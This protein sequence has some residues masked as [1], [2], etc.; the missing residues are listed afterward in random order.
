MPW[1]S[2]KLMGGLP[3]IKPVSGGS[4][5]P[6][7]QPLLTP[8]R[9]QKI[10]ELFSLALGRE[11][12]QRAA[13][14]DEVCEGDEALRAE[15]ESLLASAESEQAATRQ[16]FKSVSTQPSSPA[17]GDAEDPMI[18]RR[19]GDYR[20][21]RRIGYGGMAAVYLASRADEQF[22]MHAAI[23]V[24]R[25]D[26]D[27]AELL[28]RFFNERQTLA[29]L[30]HP[31]I[32]KLLDGG[33]T[34]E[35]LPYLVMD[36]VEGVPIDEYCDAHGLSIQKRLQLFCTVCEAVTYAHQHHVIHRDLKPNNILVTADGTTKLLDFGIAKV[37][38]TSEASQVATRTANRHLTPAFAS[39][40]QVRGETVAATTDVYSLG[41]VLYAL[42]TGRRPYRIKER[43]PA[44][45]ERAICEQ[46]PESPSTAV[47]R[48]ETETRPDG[49]TVTITAESVSRT[50]EGQPEKLRRSLRGDLDNI[51][52]K[53]LRKEPQRRYRT[54]AELS[55]DIQRH[56]EHLPIQARR[57]TLAYRGSKFIRRHKTEVTALAMMVAVMLAAIGYTVWEQSLA[58][59]RARVELASQRSHGRRSVAVLGFKN[60]S[61]RSDTAWLSTALSEMLSTELT[62]G[63]KLRTIPGESVAQTKISL[64]LPE[65]ESLSRETLGRV[66]KN[67]GSDF[68]VLG[69]FLDVGDTEGTIRLDLRVQDAGLGDTIANLA[70]SGSTTALPDLVTRAGA[71]VRLKLGIG[72][73]PAEES[74]KVQASLPS[75]PEAT[76]LYAE[77]LAKLRMS[78]A[79]GARDLLNKA[80][81]VDPSNALAHSALAEAWSG[82]GYVGKA[83]QEAKTAFDRSGNLGREEALL[84]EGRYHEADGNWEKALDIYKTLFNFFPD[85]LE[86]GLD[87]VSVQTDASKGSDAKVTLQA[88][89]K[90]P[91]PS[92]DDPRV[93]LQESYAAGS[94][95][96]YKLQA[97]AAER[98][99]QKADSN[100]AR[101]LVAQC[102]LTQGRALQELGQP[103]K[104]RVVLQRALGIF[105]AAGNEFGRARTLHELGLVASHSSHF[106][107]AKNDYGEAL[108][109]LRNLG[110]RLNEA[111]VWNDIGNLFASQNDLKAQEEAVKKAL[112]IF[113]EI[114]NQ[115][116]IATALGNLGDVEGEQGDNVNA[117]QHFQEALQMDRELGD[118]NA[119]AYDLGNLAN[120]L[121]AEGEFPA[122]QRLLEE[123]V[124]ISR[125]TGEKRALA[126]ALYNL[127]SVRTSLGDLDKAE[128]VY[129]ESRQVFA[130][131]GN[132]LGETGA[133]SG[134]GDVR[135]KKGDLTG[136]RKLNEDALAKREAI[137]SSAWTAENRMAIAEISLEEGRALEAETALRHVIEDFRAH[138]DMTSAAEAEALLI[139]S[140]L[141]QDKRAD[142]KN[143]ALEAAQ[144]AAKS[145]DREAAIYAI[146]AG[147]RV[148]TALGEIS[149]AVK[150]LQMALTNAR[151]LGIVAAQFEVRL[152][153]G[154]TEMKSRNPANGRAE[155]ASL[156]RDARTKGFLLLARKAAACRK[157][158]RV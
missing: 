98:A 11:P 13:L 112:A 113:R 43:T 92:G 64:S 50:R 7:I 24:L 3:P 69:S 66:Y 65:A 62:A 153:L 109:I 60:L 148:H 119:A 156:E 158:R 100:G 150:S 40:E 93:D 23:K 14:L 78:D 49:T 117:R 127:A 71:E 145:G 151:K 68:V 134:L 36:Y 29:A 146:L 85:N 59:E 22:Q 132:K 17:V 76:R 102:L 32:V 58:T 82:L 106:E 121:M 96:D 157:G 27:R 125:R 141:A 84:V 20:I 37:L 12:E 155:L 86:Y 70:M 21:E 28:R 54:V 4:G 135:L 111:K 99:A 18:G 108:N 138:D 81:L 103:D 154:E 133:I 89:R 52:I 128:Q 6:R 19:V 122:A 129:S 38:G 63:G 51:V 142:A 16:V 33:S 1:G 77:G 130:D 118:Q 79:L 15:V 114:G 87:L 149:E 39:P 25:P 115:K 123:S 75:N 42:L 26:L 9:W 110:N 91:Y 34:E 107:E 101:L 45:L 126:F 116:G 95:S 136:A 41:V 74:S 48:V 139:N 147:A 57:T 144:L 46:E 131:A 140:F 72:T 2:P 44:A 94:I 10:K 90:L 143:A 47:D 67:L 137:G 80:I 31:H 35:G 30:D 56:L 97:L 5:A 61:G 88:L 8:Q 104:A 124:K 55:E 53:A 152:A 105:A 83:K 120:V 73:I